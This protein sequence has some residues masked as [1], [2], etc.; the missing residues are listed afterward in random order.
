V[1][2]VEGVLPTI[3]LTR[4]EAAFCETV[5]H[6]RY[7]ANLGRP[8]AYG[9]AKDGRDEEV[10]GCY[11]EY[12]VSLWLDRAWR[13]VVDD[14]WS[15]IEGDVGQLQVRTTWNGRDPHLICHP[16]D[17]DEAT[18]VLVSRQDWDTFR[19]EGW[20]TGATAK[21][22]TYWSDKYGHNRPAFFVPARDLYHPDQMRKL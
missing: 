8:N 10:L 20:L 19:I 5:G 9:L 17:K 21:D 16:R 13:A 1:N 14:P 18:F 4:N 12:C 7:M 15:E 2:T 11:G 6:L 3:H 22:D